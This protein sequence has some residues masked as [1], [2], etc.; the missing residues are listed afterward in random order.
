MFDASI[1]FHQNGI[2]FLVAENIVIKT[3][4]IIIIIIVIL[5]LPTC[6]TGKRE[7]TVSKS[8]WLPLKE[9]EGDLSFNVT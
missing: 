7:K 3:V 1:R 2:L 5:L 6:M 8:D 4:I 9:P